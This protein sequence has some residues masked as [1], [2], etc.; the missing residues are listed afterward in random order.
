MLN[1]CAHDSTH[2]SQGWVPATILTSVSP[3][4]MS[5][6]KWST[7]RLYLTVQPKRV[8]GSALACSSFWLSAR[9]VWSIR[10]ASCYHFVESY[11]QLI[12]LTKMIT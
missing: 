3:A 11:C 5:M 8:T 12:L 4:D 1:Y 7:D 10:F 9:W 2:T 6:V